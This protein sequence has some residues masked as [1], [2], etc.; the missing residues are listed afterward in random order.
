MFSTSLLRFASHFAMHLFY[1]FDYL[2]F[3]VNIFHKL[4]HTNKFAKLIYK[5]TDIKCCR[6]YRLWLP[7]INKD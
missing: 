2:V 7:D 4:C 3:F 1:Y 6:S 5:V